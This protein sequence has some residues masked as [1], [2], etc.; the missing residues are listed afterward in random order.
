MMLTFAALLG[1]A[2]ATEAA[3]SAGPVGLADSAATLRPALAAELALAS[4]DRDR[5]AGLL[6]DGYAA[7]AELAAAADRVERLSRRV[8]ECDGLMARLHA[9]PTG[10]VEFWLD[11]PDAAVP[12]DRTAVDGCVRLRDEAGRLA[13]AVRARL[14]ADR[15][16]RLAPE[17][18]EFDRQSLAMAHAEARAAVLVPHPIQRASTAD[19]AA[20]LAA[21]AKR[22]RTIGRVPPRPV[23]MM[24]LAAAVGH[25]DRVA[26]LALA[27]PFFRQEAADASDRVR[28]LRGRLDQFA[29]PARSADWWAHECDRLA[30][31][32]DRASRCAEAIRSLQNDGFASVWERLRA[33]TDRHVA[34]ADWIAAECERE[35]V[36]LRQA[37]HPQAEILA[38]ER[39]CGDRR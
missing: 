4:F 22:L 10:D 19:E 17:D 12:L 18:P 1:P 11:D 31:C 3:V 32:H 36:H 13:G 34:Q 14:Q 39:L 23:S 21:I 35:L 28:M 27:D 37:G 2:E 15:S 5:L 20:V 9:I 38:N 7:P 25:R 33:E 24:D 30:G 29:V 6:A 26:E 16:T 8:A